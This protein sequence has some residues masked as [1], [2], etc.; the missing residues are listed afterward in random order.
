MICSNNYD[1]RVEA[2]F[3][4]R[5]YVFIV[6]KSQIAKKIRINTNRNDDNNRWFAKFLA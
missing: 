5:L 1:R 3:K 4:R 2:K 6:D